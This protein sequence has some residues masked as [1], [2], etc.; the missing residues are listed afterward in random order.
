MLIRMLVLANSSKNRGRCLA[1]LNVETGKWVRPVPNTESRVIDNERTIIA[2]R[3]IR[4][5]DL[6]D[7]E[8]GSA[9][10]LL[11]HPL[12]RAWV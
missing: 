7:V 2:D 3:F 5:G 11:Y 4:P 12:C 9:L 8:I 1:G 10:P 6:I